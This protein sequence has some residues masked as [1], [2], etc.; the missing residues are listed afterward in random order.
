MD[1]ITI[2]ESVFFQ[3]NRQNPTVTLCIVT[4][5]FHVHCTWLVW[6]I[7][8]NK[9]DYFLHFSNNVLHRAIIFH[10][11]CTVKTMLTFQLF[12]VIFKI[13]PVNC[14]NEIINLLYKTD[15]CIS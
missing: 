9:I 12:K 8:Q 5:T 3:I 15:S 4:L 11:K 6:C 1:L 14:S 10:A 7:Y 2:F 13:I